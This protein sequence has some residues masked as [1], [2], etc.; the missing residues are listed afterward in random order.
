MS[1]AAASSASAASV[2]PSLITRR[3]AATTAEPPTKA[4]REPTL[5][6]PFAR[7]V[8]PCTMRTLS[9]DT[10]S[11]SVMSCVYE[12]S[13][14][15][16]IACVPEKTVISPLALTSMSTV[17]VG[18]APVH[19]RYADSPRPRSLPARAEASRRAG[20]PAQSACASSRSSTAEKSPTSYVSPRCVR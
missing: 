17:S 16:P 11:T 19:S 2:L 4:E 13:S 6:T 8:S 10:P 20:K 18:S 7:S 5:P 9:G 3:P 12:V 14:P 1:A 15:C